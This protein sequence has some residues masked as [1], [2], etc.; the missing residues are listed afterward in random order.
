MRMR[1]Q[2]VYG[3][4]FKE[5]WV[6]VKLKETESGATDWGWGVKSRIFCSVLKTGDTTECERMLMEI[7]WKSGKETKLGSEVDGSWAEQKQARL[8]G[9]GVFLLDRQM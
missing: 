3:N 8:T 7:L 6:R 2:Q 1:P 5:V 9:G 4:S